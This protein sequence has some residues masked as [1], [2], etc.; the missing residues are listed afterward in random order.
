MAAYPCSVASATVSLEIVNEPLGNKSGGIIFSSV[1]QGRTIM[2][3]PVIKIALALI[4]ALAV[5]PLMVSVARADGSQSWYLSKTEAE[6][7]ANDGTW[8]SCDNIMRKEEPTSP[9]PGMQLIGEIGD[10]S[11]TAWWYSENAAEYDVTFSGENSWYVELYYLNTFGSGELHA[12]VWSVDASGNL[13]RLL[14]EGIANIVWCDGYTNVTIECG[15]HEATEQTVLEDY[16][17]A[18]RLSYEP[19]QWVDGVLLFYGSEN[20]PAHLQSPE[21]DPGYP[22]PELSTIVLMGI[23][24]AGLGGYIA[25][26]RYGKVAIS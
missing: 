21:T 13:E 24:I 16:R 19:D 1:R 9:F 10:I 17:L 6:I 22:V 4:L 7:K 14:A 26:K 11:R 23:G 5:T 15:D 25:L 12:Q 18:L 20:A 2:P 8:H 3:K